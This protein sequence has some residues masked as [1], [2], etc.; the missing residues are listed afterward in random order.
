[1]NTNFLNTKSL[2]AVFDNDRHCIGV[3]RVRGSGYKTLADIDIAG[4][5]LQAE[6]VDVL[7]EYKLF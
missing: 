6:V 1:M 2:G 5:I 7:V 4:K 3:G